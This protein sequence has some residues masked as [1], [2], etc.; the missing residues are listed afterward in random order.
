M[1]KNYVIAYYSSWKECICYY[2]FD[3][4]NDWKLKIETLIYDL[5]DEDYAD[6]LNEMYSP[7]NILGC[8]YFVGDVLKEVDPVTFRCLKSDYCSDI[9]ARVEEELEDKDEAEFLNYCAYVVEVDE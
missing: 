1:K 6:D 7:I 4:R 2:E 8:E 9:L 3:N 5:K